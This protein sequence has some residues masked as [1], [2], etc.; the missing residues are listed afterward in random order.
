MWC[1]VRD[2]SARLQR[3]HL[4]GCPI[5]RRATTWG[6]TNHTF[7]LGGCSPANGLAQK[8][9]NWS[10]LNQKVLPG[11]SLQEHHL[12]RWLL[13]AADARCKLHGLTASKDALQCSTS[14]IRCST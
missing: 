8:L 4:R 6:C 3:H 12:P 7:V 11:H 13:R 10:T 2:T 9:Y 5:S 1:C 14:G